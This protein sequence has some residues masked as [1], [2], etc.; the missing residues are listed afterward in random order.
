[1]KKSFLKPFLLTIA[2]LLFIVANT[3]AQDIKKWTFLVY[4]NVDND[5][6]GYGLNDITEMVGIGSSDSVNIILE[7]DRIEG[8]ADAWGDFTDARRFYIDQHASLDELQP[9]Q[10][11]GEINMGDPA[12]LVDFVTWGV[13]NYPAEKYSLIIGSH[14]AGWQGIGPDDSGINEDGGILTLAEINTAL[15][16]IREQ[17]GIEK[18]EFIGFDACLM[19]QLE[20]YQ[21]LQGHAKYAI[22]AEEVIP[23][24]GYNYTATL[25]Q[26]L[27]TPDMSAEE[28]LT[29]MVDSYMSFYAEFGQAYPAYDLHVVNLE[30]L[31]GVNTALANFTTVANA[32][33]GDIFSPIGAARVGSQFFSY[34]N[35][36]EYVDLIDIMGLLVQGTESPE[37]QSAAQAVI[38]AVIASVFYTRTTAS[39]PG[40]NGISIYFP[41]LADTFFKDAYVASGIS[42]LMTNDWIGFLDT[43]HTTASTLL[44][45]NNLS[46]EITGVD[47]IAD[48]ASILAPPTINFQTTGTA[49][50]DL[51]SI[52]IYRPEEG[53]PVIVVQTPLAIYSEDEEGYLRST[54]PDGD[55]QSSYTWDVTMSYMD[56]E[57][58]Q[59]PILVEYLSR[60]NQFKAGGIF[61][62]GEECVQAN[63]FFDNINY[64]MLSVWI[65]V[66]REDSSVTAQVIPLPGDTFN[67]SVAVITPEGAVESLTLNATYTFAEGITPSFYYAPAIS[68]N[69]SISLLI[70]DLTGDFRVAN[71][72]IPIDNTNMPA[73]L[74]GFPE[75]TVLGVNFAYPLVWGD[76]SIQYTETNTRYYVADYEGRFF[77]NLELYDAASLDDFYASLESFFVESIAMVRDPFPIATATGYNGIAIEYEFGDG[78][79]GYYLLFYENEIGYL[80]D[81][82]QPTGKDEAT[83]NPILDIFNNTVS[84]FPPME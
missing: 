22:A 60:S 70:R 18:F 23:G 24:N 53:N 3:S 57:G 14:G 4:M 77:I 28:L 11:L 75:A 37:I 50:I 6:E 47:Q 30:A 61:C 71:A 17:T 78:G 31:D 9:V 12:N 80:F 34:A 55:Y 5:L 25:T 68:G 67:P 82:Y 52:A 83:F 46:I 74:R 56:I 48:V 8:Y 66:Q 49:I 63:L 64:Q 35:N 33:M 27:T 62:R 73:D 32:N 38:D 45:D 26:L 16:T 43:F 36:R 41:I 7:I 20:V 81:L 51:Q 29:V 1:M 72:N 69:Y 21:A 59:T 10:E 15:T 76:S 65:T 39:M 54:Y 58:T 42:P 84:F 2:M 40:A 13:A 44:A 79:Y 19:G